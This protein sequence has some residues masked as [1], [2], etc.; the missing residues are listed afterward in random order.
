M[1][2]LVRTFRILKLMKV[3]QL[4]KSLKLGSHWKF[5]YKVRENLLKTVYIAI[6][7]FFVVH[8]AACCFA[9]IG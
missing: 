3:S 8:L 9:G 7:T 6:L 4:L 2:K 5:V 1:P